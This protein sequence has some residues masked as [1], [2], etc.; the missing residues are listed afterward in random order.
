MASE[1]EEEAKPAPKKHAKKKGKKG[2]KA[3]LEDDYG[4]APQLVVAEVVSV[5]QHPNADKLKVC[6]VDSRTGSFKVVT[7]AL[8]VSEG[9]KV[10]FAAV[11]C[12]TPGSGQKVTQASLRGVDSF[13]MLCSAFETGWADEPD[14]VLIEMPEDAQ[15]GEDV[16]PVPPP[17]AKWGNSKTAEA[18]RKSKEKGFDALEEPDSLVAGSS[19]AAV[20]S[21]DA[22]SHVS[23][24]KKKKAKKTS[25]DLASA[26]AAL[27]M[28][29]EGEGAEPAA[30]AA[31][32]PASPPADAQADDSLMEMSDEAVFGKKKKKSK[33][34]GADEV[35][36]AFAALEEDEDAAEASPDA[37][38][39]DEVVTKGKKSRKKD[40]TSA[41]EALEVAD[42]EPST[43]GASEEPAADAN[44]FGKKKKKKAGKGG[45][46]GDIDAIM[47]EVEGSQASRAL[48]GETAPADEPPAKGKKKKKK[49]GNAAA[50]DGED[51]DAILAELGMD[52]AEPA[53]AVTSTPEQ[54]STA[55]AESQAAPAAALPLDPAAP[56]DAAGEDD[57]EAETKGMTAAQKKKLKKKAKEK[58]KKGG[59]DDTAGGAGEAAPSTAAAAAPGGGKKVSAAVR[60]M[61]ERLEAQRLAEEAAR[62]AEEER[63]RKEEE[64]AC[65]AAEEEARKAED[66]ERRKAERKERRAQ[67]KKDGLL[68]TGRAKKEADRL[69]AMREQ[70]MKNAGLEGPEAAAEADKPAAKKKVVYDT[71]KKRPQQKKTEEEEAA[72]KAQLEQQQE[73][74]RQQE[75]AAAKAAVEAT[76]AAKAEAE[77]AAAAAAAAEGGEEEEEEDWEAAVDS[78]EEMDVDKL[79]LP[80]DKAAAKVA[81]AEAAVEE[82]GRAEG[83][84]AAEAEAEAAEGE[85]AE[86]EASEEEEGSDEEESGSESESESD[87]EDESTSYES[88]T[89]SEEAAEERLRAAKEA[90]EKRLKAALEAG[91]KDNLRSPICCILGHVDTGKTKLLDNIRRTNVQD[92]EAGGITQQIGATYVPGDALQKRTESL[93]KGREFELKL[94]GLLI[95][96]TPGHESFTNLRSRGSSLCDIAILVVDLMHGMEQQTIESINLLKM[97]KTPFIVALNKV[98]RLFDWKPIADAPIRDTLEQQKDYVKVEFEKRLAEATLNLNE[99]GLN[100]ALYWK[101]P[102][103]RKYVNIVPTSA[104]S[105]EGIPDMLQ[106]LVKLTQAMMAE[107]L[108]FISELQCTVLE[109][110]VIEGLGTTVDVVLVNGV[111]HEGDT[112]VLCGLQGPIVTN[113]RSLLTP[114]PLK[115]LRVRGS[116]LHHKEI[117]AAQGIKIAAPGMESAVAG[118]QLYVANSNEDVETLKAEVMEDMTNIFSSVDRSGEG[119]CVQASTLGSLEAL[120]EFL[121]SDAVK[122]PVSAINIGP[123]HK[124][125]IMRASVMLEKGRKKYACLLAFDVEVT[126]EAREVADK[127]GVRIFQA[128]IIYHLFDQFTAFLKQ[129]KEE[130]QEAAKLEAVFP[131]ILRILPTCIFNKK[132]PIVLGVDVEEGIAKVG[133][134]VCIPTQGGINLGRIASMELNHKP[135]DTAKRGDSVAMKIDATT[136][137]ESARLYGRHFDHRDAIVSRITRKSIDL[138]KQHFK[139]DMSRDDWRLILKLK[140]MF[141]ID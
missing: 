8:N 2:R 24:G 112:I 5:Q 106:L 118:T 52:K 34:K 93:R 56:V 87:S 71:R 84:P 113:I 132:D 138:L 135:V 1:E 127:L 42:T 101:N 109:V 3:D 97:R 134:P 69:A 51:L 100:V 104:I 83:K 46:E 12:T 82:A 61:Q 41:F 81:A 47:A 123:I 26:F 62:R 18:G 80:G 120:L 89:D 49:G 44:G 28:E 99:Q 13:G 88:E 15:A 114:H 16:P 129:V 21:P 137:E 14:G 96:D 6:M 63:I 77:A 19:E 75:L 10:V 119:V 11:G 45:A 53:A 30:Q 115:E 130:E 22:S 17:G 121:K 36:S 76:A 66:A 133:T 117:R 54:A 111:L 125:D 103:P 67:L 91:D 92:G 29:G 68:L 4:E 140:K 43:T 131:C 40:V 20:C 116:Y 35:S 126:R 48:A 74:L 79:Q 78:W 70:F 55:P 50:G 124:R 59:A 90:R 94:P 38:G 98:D 105:G 107:R 86:E 141:Q 110:K 85:A 32:Q 33:K 37:D 73:A 39:Q 57:E 108:M 58:A 72:D 95:I 9:M 128:D 27:G 23:G 25:A 122:I 136:T 139:D 31:D 60:K 102:D 7:N 65:R 64:E